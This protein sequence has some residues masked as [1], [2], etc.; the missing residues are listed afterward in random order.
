MSLLNELNK[1]VRVVC[2]GYSIGVFFVHFTD[3]QRTEERK[4]HAEEARAA[5]ASAE[6]SQQLL[7][8]KERDRKRKQTALPVKVRL[9]HRTLYFFFL[10]AVCPLDVLLPY[11]SYLSLLRRE[12][13]FYIM[14]VFVVCCMSHRT[15]SRELAS[16]RPTETRPI[17]KLTRVT[18]T[19][20]TTMRWTLSLDRTVPNLRS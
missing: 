2:M 8:H 11:P 3:N 4:Q 17:C 15:T 6:A 10:T 9:K 20:G 7:H 19:R 16:R 12:H 13:P 1:T 5:K 18:T 14:T